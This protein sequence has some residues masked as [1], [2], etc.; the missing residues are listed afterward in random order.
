METLCDVLIGNQTYLEVAQKGLNMNFYEFCKDKGFLDVIESWDDETSMEDVSLYSHKKY[1]FKCPVCGTTKI[2]GLAGIKNNPN[3]KFR[4]VRCNSF[5]VWCEKNAKKWL[6]QWDYDKNNVSPYDIYLSDGHKYYFKCDRGLHESELTRVADITNKGYELKYRCRKCNSFAQWCIDNNETDLLS[7]WDIEKNKVSAWDVTFS[8]GKKYY[9]KCPRSL[10]ESEPKIL[11]NI[12]RQEGTK[13][14]RQCNSFKQILI[15][16]FGLKYFDTVWSDKNE[17]NPYDLTRRCDKKVWLNCAENANHPAFL[18]SC[19]NYSKGERCPICRVENTTSRLQN[20]V[21]DYINSKKKYTLL[22]EDKCNLS[23]I[24]PKTNMPLRY[25]NEIVELKI[26]IEVMGVQHYEPS[27][28]NQLGSSKYG[29]TLEEYFKYSQWKDEF[30]KQFVLDNGYFYLEIPYW[31][32]ETEEYKEL[33]DDA[34]RTQT[35][36]LQ[37]TP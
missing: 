27:Y 30:K 23:P 34:I 31:T 8:S 3:F 12:I 14:C 16:R 32:E 25:D 36:Q 22:H 19:A 35:L 5:G 7:R 33:I 1:R 17:I 11:F 21:M 26:I 4:C 20:K 28:F 15:D 10:H 18:M 9:F 24:N 6:E 37:T 13:K 2:Q 29:I